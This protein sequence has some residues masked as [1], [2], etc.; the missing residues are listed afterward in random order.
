[1]NEHDTI[2][3]LRECDA[4][5][6]MGVASIDEVLGAVNSTEFRNRLTECKIEHEK[7]YREIREQ[8]D[9]RNATG[10]A[11]NPMAKGMS[12]MKTNTK[13]M[14]HD[15]DATIADV[16]TDGCDMG[17]KSLN[18]F[19]NRYYD[20]DETAK[21]IAKRLIRSEERLSIDMRSYL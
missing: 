12:W 2:E 3:L 1:M 4:G 18:K 13:L 9:A 10:K 6:Q 11:P 14:M 21:D 8:L 20:A 15:S 7:M 19:L 17:V 5:V 16:L